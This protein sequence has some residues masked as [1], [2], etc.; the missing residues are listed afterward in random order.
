VLLL[1]AI[2]VVALG[3]LGLGF[4]QLNRLEERRARND[5]IRQRLTQPALMVD[6]ALLAMDVAAL[7]YRPAT[8]RGKFDFAHEIVWRNQ[9]RDGAPGVHVI[10][11]LRLAGSETAVLVDRGWIPYTQA[12]PEARAA[13]QTPAGEVA[14]SGWLR[15]PVTRTADFLPSD[16]TRGPDQPR[17]DAWFWLDIAQIQ[18]QTPYPL[19]PM[20]LVQAPG[21]ETAGKNPARLPLPEPEPELS[22]GAHL[23]YAIQWFAFA[24]IALLGPF[25]YWRRSLRREPVAVEK[26]GGA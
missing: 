12:E 6:D 14:V 23:V 17:L 19:L 18:A 3:M 15:R 24:A 7:D 8:A 16:P 11:P 5:E 20:L 21:P 22:E 10:T 26:S 4:W 2:P 1:S 13:F 25:I 9:A